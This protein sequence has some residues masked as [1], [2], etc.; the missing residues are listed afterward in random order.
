MTANSR[1]P[2]YKC[3]WRDVVA[4]NFDVDPRLLKPWIPKGTRLLPFQDHSLVTLMAK[5]IRDFHPAGRRLNLFP[6]IHEIDLRTYV[7]WESNGVTRLGHFKLKNLVS[8]KLAAWVFHWLTG[9]PQITASIDCSTTN[10]EEARRDAMPTAE[11]RWRLENLESHFKVSARTQA[12][13]S[14]DDSKELFV[15]RQEHRFVVSRRGTYCY[16]IRQAPWLV[17]NASSGSFDVQ[18]QQF[19]DKELR[20]YFKRPKF[21]L[22]SR[23]GEVTVSRGLKVAELP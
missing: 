2:I 20:K 18:I 3:E 22:L 13:K 23:G 10:F 6:S 14:Q 1:K 16:P 15:L 21:V 11:Y 12:S 17:W 19:V 9:Q 5:H 8:G 7:S 4:L